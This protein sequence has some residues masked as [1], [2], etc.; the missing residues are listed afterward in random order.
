MKKTHM[1]LGNLQYVLILVN[2]NFK[3]RE[4]GVY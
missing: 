1:K 2:V 3:F 4:S